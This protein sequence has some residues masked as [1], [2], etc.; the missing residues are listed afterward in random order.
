MT[1]LLL[2]FQAWN[3][4]SSLVGKKGVRNI[5]ACPS[6]FQSGNVDPT[7]DDWGVWFNNTL[8]R[9]EHVCEQ[10]DIVG[11]PQP[12]F[13]HS[14]EGMTQVSVEEAPNMMTFEQRHRPL[15]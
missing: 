3:V 15:F 6:K 14:A 1:D 10:A 7:S 13:Q 4:A 12:L 8:Q 5:C 9:L 11:Q 2:V